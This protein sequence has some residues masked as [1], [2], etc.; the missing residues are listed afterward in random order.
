MFIAVLTLGFLNSCTDEEKDAPTLD[1]T[2]VA[3]STYA[4]GSIVTYTILVSS[5][6]DLEYFEAAPTSGG[7]PGTGIVATLPIDVLTDDEL[8][9]YDFENNLTSV[10]ITYV[11]AIPTNLAPGSTVDIVYYLEDA[12]ADNTVT[13]S[14]TV[15]S[16]AGNID[17]FTAVLMGNQQN[18]TLGSFYS[19]ST[20]DVFTFAEVAANK[21]LIDLVY[22][23]GASDGITIA[24]PN[25]DHAAIVFSNLDGT[26]N[27]TMF[28]NGVTF[29]AADFSAADS[30]EILNNVTGTET[31][32]VSME[33]DDMYGFV[34]AAGKKGAF[35]VSA[36]N[37]V[38]YGETS[39]L[40]IEVI[41]QE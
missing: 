17:R 20:D 40:T 5:N 16:G 35:M 21:S 28:D 1:I 15:A 25:D 34:T 14:F 31:R 22:Y 39:T 3:G 24:A 9:G 41:V 23:L 7:G 32:V 30:D 10:T 26:F 11:Y 12:D 29:S 18:T 6:V 4:V 2:E 13:K 36:V 37:G 8:G 33:V 19:T 27:A 38:T